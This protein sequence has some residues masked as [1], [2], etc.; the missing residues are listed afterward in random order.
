MNKKLKIVVTLFL[1]LTMLFGVM[2]TTVLAAGD[3]TGADEENSTSIDTLDTG[4]CEIT[5]DSKG[6][7]VTLNPDVKSLLDV[8]KEEIR[9]VL[10]ILIDALKAIVVGDLK[11]DIL[12]GMAPNAQEPA[13]Q[14]YSLRSAA[15]VDD[16]ANGGDSGSGLGGFNMDGIW[17]T[18]LGGFI[19][20]RYGASTPEEYMQF[21]KDILA[22][23][24]ADDPTDA[25]NTTTED[26]ITYACELIRLA[27]ATGQV[28]VEDLPEVT[29]ALRDSIIDAFNVKIDEYIDDAIEEILPQYAEDYLSDVV[30]DGKLGYEPKL[31]A[32]IKRLIDSTVA[33]YIEAEVNE[34]INNGFA[35]LPDSTDPVDPIVGNYTDGQIKVKVKLWLTNYADGKLSENP[36]SIN[37]L[38]D[39]KMQTYI[40]EFVTHYFAGTKPE[41]NPIYDHIKELADTMRDDKVL[42]YKNAFLNKND[43]DSDIKALMYDYLKVMV[44]DLFWEKRDDRLGDFDDLSDDVSFGAGSIW[45]KIEEELL[46]KV[47]EMLI[48]EK[49]ET[50]LKDAIADTVDKGIYQVVDEAIANAVDDAIVDAIDKAIEEFTSQKLNEAVA[51]LINK[52]VTEAGKKS[53]EDAGIDENAS[54]YDTLLADACEEIRK[55]SDAYD[56]IVAKAETE[57]DTILNDA[58]FKSKV[59][60]EREKILY[61][62]NEGEGYE[63]EFNGEKQKIQ[64]DEIIAKINGEGCEIEFN[65]EKQKV[66]RHEIIEKINKEG[67]TITIGGEEKTFK[68]DDILKDVFEGENGYSF[69]IDG[70]TVTLK[71]KEIYD[72]IMDKEGAGYTVTIGSETISVT[73]Q[74]IYDEA[75]PLVYEEYCKTSSEKIKEK[76]DSNQVTMIQNE[77]VAAIDQL[78]ATERNNIWNNEL[79]AKERDDVMNKVQS[80]EVFKNLVKN[81]VENRWL[82][83]ENAVKNRQDAVA[84][85][86]YNPQ[87]EE[88]F[89]SL[90]ETMIDEALTTKL[91]EIKNVVAEIWKDEAAILVEF[92]AM[93]REL[94]EDAADKYDVIKEAVISKATSIELTDDMISEVFVQIFGMTRAETE[95]KIKDPIISTF[96]KKYAELREELLKSPDVQLDYKDLIKYIK[97]IKINDIVLYENGTVT[98]ESI[99][100]LLAT[101]PTPEEIKNM[102]N[103]EMQLSYKISVATTLNTETEITLTARLGGGYDKVRK[104]AT[105][106]CE[107]VDISLGEGNVLNLKVKVP[108]KFAKLVL[109]AINYDDIPDRLE[110]QITKEQLD[111][112]KKKIFDAF[113]ES[114]NDVYALIK[115]VTL[116]ELLTLFDYVDLDKVLDE[117]LDIEYLSRF[118][119]LDGLTEEQIKNKI[120]EYE[121]QYN[122]LIKL[123]KNFYNNHIPDRFKDATIF[124]LYDGSGKFSFAGSKTVNIENVLNKFSEKYGALIASFIDVSTVEGGID[125]EIEFEQINKV[126]FKLDGEVYKTGLLPAGAN[127]AYFAGITS[128]Y[129]ENI[130]GWRDADGVVYTTMPDKDVVLEPEY[131]IPP[132]AEP[133]E[134]EISG[135]EHKVYDGEEVTLKAEIKGEIPAG[136]TKITYQWYKRAPIAVMSIRLRSIP[137]GFDAVEGATDSELKLKNVKD[138]GEYF[139]ELTFS[140]KNNNSV[141]VITDISTVNIIPATPAGV[142]APVAKGGLVFNNAPQELIIPGTTVGGTMVYQ[143]DGESTYSDVIPK[144]TNAG[145]YTVYYWVQG[146]DNY[147]DVPGGSIT[148]VIDKKSPDFTKPVLKT[149]LEYNAAPQSLLASNGE[150][151]SGKILYKVNDGEYSET[152]P[153]A[154]L[155]GIYEI[156]CKVE[157]TDANYYGITE[158]SLGEVTIEPTGNYNVFAPIAKPSLVYNG[159]AQELINAGYVEI[160]G[161]NVAMEYKLEGDTDYSSNIPVATNAG[162]YRVYYRYTL[163][164]NYAPHDSNGYVDVEIAK[165]SQSFTQLPIAN[166]GLKYNGNEQILITAGAASNGTVMYKIKGSPFAYSVELPKASEAGTYIIEYMADGGNNY[167]D[168]YGELEITVVIDKAPAAYEA[169]PEAMQNLVYNGNSQT[170][171]KPGT[172]SSNCGWILYRLSTD[173]EYSSELPV[174]TNS[175][176]YTVYYKIVGDANHYDSEEGQ[177]TVVIGKYI[178]DLT[179]YFWHPTSFVY[180]GKEKA[181]YLVNENGDKLVN[182]L[183]YTGN[184]ATNAGTYIAAVEVADGKNFKFADNDTF[185][186]AFEWTIEKATVDMSGISFKNVAVKYDGLAHSL[187]I[188]GTLPEGVT[189]E[190]SENSFTAPGTYTVTAMFVVSDNY[191]EIPSMTATLTI[192]GFK[193]QHEI[194]DTDNKLIVRV[195]SENGIVETYVLNC[196]DVTA[197]YDSFDFDDV[198]GEGLKGVLRGAYDIH[199]A[200]DGTQLKVTDKF[201]VKLLIPTHLRNTANTLK[202]VHIADNGAVEDMNATVDGDYMVFNTTH[203][204]VYSIVEVMEKTVADDPSADDNNYVWLWILLAI[205]A[206]LIIAAII[207]FIVQKNT[208]GTEPT[209]TAEQTLTAPT[210]E[211]T[212]PETTESDVV[213]EPAVEEPAVEEP[214]VEEPAVEEPA[215]EEPA[216]EEAAVEE[217]AVEEAPVKEASAAPAITL[218]GNDNGEVVHVRYRTSFMSRLIQSGDVMQNYYTALK[219]A[220]LSYK[221]VKARSSWNFESFNKG[222]V[223]CAKLNVKGTALQLYLALDPKEYNANKYHFTDVSDKPKLDEVPMMLKIKSD[224]ALKYALELIEEMMSKLGIE[225]GKTSELDFH[226][227][228]ET[229]EELASRGLVKV[230]LPKGVTLDGDENLVK[231]NVG[232]M[233]DV[234]KSAT[235]VEEPAVE[236]L[237]EEAPVEEAP[238]APAITLT[239][240]YN[241]EVVHVR[242]RTSFMSRLIQSGDVM[243]N[244]YTALKNALLS[245][246]GV[247]ARSSWNFE[248]FNK[249]R[250]QCA[251][252]NVKG[253]ALQLYLA[254]DPKEYNANKYHFT[255]VSDKPKL[256]EVPMMLK[257]KSDRALKYALELIEEMMSKLGIEEGKTSE[258]DFHMP[259]E[260][261]EELASRGL[262]KVI[263]PKGVT[264]DGDENLVKVNVGEMLDSAKAAIDAA[265]LAID[266]PVAEETVAEELPAETP[267]E[268]TVHVD[269]IHADEIL[270]DEEAES[271]IEVVERVPGE[272]GQGKLALINLDTICENFEDGETVTLEALKA[273]RLVNKNA[274]RIKILA[275]GVM[276]KKLTVYAD[277]FSLQAVKMITLAGGHADQYK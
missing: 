88:I 30:N 92:Y 255:D 114:P 52:G 71:Y 169:M 60:E 154:T 46:E 130:K 265:E 93:I 66:Q 115:D 211:P 243:Q 239:G 55:D 83:G 167:E 33:D 44:Y 163:D 208:D 5:Y 3:T 229:T 228:Y 191:N 218:T 153:V 27:V 11:N 87:Y 80:S 207:L 85:I 74:D 184:V 240:N 45:L 142:V 29:D 98:V 116:D 107:H 237:V 6:I 19:E 40:S 129:G 13:P 78:D 155:A 132:I 70:N 94:A 187:S 127:L 84:E 258:L 267:A 72:A 200:E 68:R 106:F 263:L 134:V 22:D 180:D 188:S 2:S 271:K 182:G 222:R 136:F 247:K 41:N 195:Q 221:G 57:R 264:L 56:E 146:G 58:E 64:R 203:F 230:I 238:A 47:V 108:A 117:A 38:I 97:N 62:I 90:L 148:V 224:R 128:H 157:S 272:K 111:K 120:K 49:I 181:V 162:K 112:L 253:T 235:D 61:A 81:E 123:A 23:N 270:S 138:S 186:T 192:I 214:A 79:T 199:F 95:A 172:V 51:E 35:V 256:D 54:D 257:I 223:Q 145:T 236:E 233:L 131:D 143:L 109:K 225:E 7:T 189:V 77:I 166:T 212:S 135:G 48:E 124:D 15:P 217:P 205:I 91:D 193:N 168:I 4:W 231:V 36:A 244:Y 159:S 227:P 273:K 268:Q 174:A 104:L 261:T 165:A 43:M 96:F 82:R 198:F 220:L 175:G 250:V 121:E 118:E 28:K 204:S 276:T 215:V 101:I 213:E 156:W 21:M 102:S 164:S 16:A 110:G 37:E 122:K 32:S 274:G 140:D 262:V 50:V 10:Y 25:T 194:I 185:V 73:Y 125:A 173:S 201:T 234:A 26:F 275:R 63:I 17:T 12:G 9:A 8:N 183:K 76:L 53:L 196:K 141:K 245:Y 170:L 89:D 219:N 251:K 209:S 147:E 34:Y 144:A 202:V 24:T 177:L 67:Y 103:E 158:T 42:E 31:D 161:S 179:G 126:T 232:E 99:K 149:E 260:T 75:Y 152:L 206:L 246:K 18:A 259:Y 178:I 160:L 252:L 59:A 139:C 210:E 249:G 216:V 176:T 69:T 241:G 86:I 119:K 269:A 242:Y 266:A 113:D 105:L 14:T 137:A 150:V 20:D 39:V 100:A 65:G 1:I 277:K 226:M 190:Y 151:E 197:I 133:P 171:I 248:S 254:L